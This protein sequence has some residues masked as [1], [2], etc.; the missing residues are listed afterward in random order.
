[1][2]FPVYT[3]QIVISGQPVHNV[4]V[5]TSESNADNHIEGK[6]DFQS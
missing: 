6:Y 2:L 4:P 3:V 1:M 5:G